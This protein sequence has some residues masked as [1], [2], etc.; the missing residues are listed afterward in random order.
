MRKLISMLR[1]IGFT[2]AV[3]LLL[4]LQGTGWAGC[5]NTCT[6]S[7]EAAEVAPPLNCLELDVSDEDCD[8]GLHVRFH[9]GCH[10]D[11]AASGFV[12]TTCGHYSAGLTVT[13]HC[14]V[15]KAGEDA[16][17]LLTVAKS[18]GTGRKVRE[19]QLD[20]PDGTRTITTAL[21]V[22]NFRSGG[23]GCAFLPG[24]H[25]GN[26]MVLAL[27]IGLIL[28]RRRYGNSRRPP[29]RGARRG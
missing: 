12:F 5:P 27:T 1:S 24:D 4:G 16:V 10:D 6:L 9:N 19:L 14:P 13:D 21:T 17:L 20:G 25:A 11:L 3:A 15:L 8:C 2:V 7:H 29:S 26:A 23:L 18:D 22:T 28:V